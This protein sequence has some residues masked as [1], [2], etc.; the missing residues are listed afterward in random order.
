MR[1]NSSSG[2]PILGVSVL[3]TCLA[4]DT[5][6]VSRNRTLISAPLECVIALV[7]ALMRALFE[8]S[9]P[10]NSFRSGKQIQSIRFAEENEFSE[11]VLQWKQRSQSIRRVVGS[12]C[13]QLDS[14]LSKHA[15]ARGPVRET[16]ELVLEQKPYKSATSAGGAKSEAIPIQHKKL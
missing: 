11:F 9:K 1:K 5:S 6:V 4:V 15:A 3:C 16:C 13:Y 10:V 14:F 8:S 2:R 12:S 7:N